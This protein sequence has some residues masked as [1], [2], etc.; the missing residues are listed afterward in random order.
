MFKIVLIYDIVNIDRYRLI[1]INK[2]S[3]V[4]GGV[5]NNIMR[6]VFTKG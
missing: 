5:L 3:L 1:L 4:G 6:V 2:T